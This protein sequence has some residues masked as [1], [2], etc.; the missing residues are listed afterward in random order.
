[1]R[2]VSAS[3]LSAGAIL[4][5]IAFITAAAGSTRAEAASD[6]TVSR[7]VAGTA[8]VTAASDDLS[9]VSSDRAVAM[10]AIARRTSTPADAPSDRA[11]EALRA[12]ADRVTRSSHSDALRTAFTAYYNYRSANP[13]SVTKPY[14]YY[15]DMGLDNGT[16][17]GYVFDMDQLTVVDGPFTVAHGRGSART[18]DGVPT[19]F[20]NRPGSKATSLGLYLAQETYNFSGKSGGRRYTSVGL[21]MRGES[22]KFNSAARSRGIVAHGA[23]YVTAGSAGRSEGCPAMEMK[24]AQRLLPMIANGGVVF[25]YSPKASDWLSRDPWILAD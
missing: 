21:R 4:V 17:R 25:I 24:R 1:M 13:G 18:R 10:P 12:L 9:D 6:G 3:R 19:S 22:G 14:L 16:A 8:P 5:I 15:V 7:L 23:P 2:P 20:S 11:D